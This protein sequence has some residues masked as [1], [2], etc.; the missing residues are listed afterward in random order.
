[1]ESE[2]LPRHTS[3]QSQIPKLQIAQQSELPTPF[4]K[5]NTTHKIKQLVYY[6][7]HMHNKKKRRKKRKRRKKQLQKH[8]LLENQPCRG[9]NT[10]KER[11]NRFL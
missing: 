11:L 9:E 8:D 6:F 5:T 7:Q 4:Q 1:M 2:N 3:N 10:S